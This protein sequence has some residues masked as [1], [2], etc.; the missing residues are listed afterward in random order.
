MRNKIEIEDFVKN[1]DNL[2]KYDYVEIIDK[3]NNILGLFVSEKYA[4]EVKEFLDAKL[5]V[6]NRVGRK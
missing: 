3:K 4:K 1:F 5:E 6:Q 2:Q